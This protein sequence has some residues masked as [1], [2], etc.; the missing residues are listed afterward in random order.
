MAKSKTSALRR[1]VMRTIGRMEKRGYTIS[2][3]T[4]EK[5]K[6]GNW[7]TLNQYH[8][9]DYQ[10]LY[11]EAKAKVDGEEVSGMVKRNQERS[12]AAQR[13]AITR[14]E[15]ADRK[16]AEEYV[17]RKY[18]AQGSAMY[19][20]LRDLVAHHFGKVGATLLN[21]LIDIE[22]R[23][24]GYDKFV[25]SLALAPEDVVEKANQ[26]AACDSDDL[27]SNRHEEP[28]DALVSIIIQ[29]QVDIERQIKLAM[30]MESKE[31]D[32]AAG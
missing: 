9:K 25:A 21:N 1:N 17:F 7:Q 11:R 16:K 2:S 14:K 26:L 15:R 5:I 27:R 30:D 8:K 19:K 28:Y 29:C 23:I 12:E 32:Y 22:I 4:K 31:E 13:G 3:E 10:K 6:T 24:F 20:T 18:N